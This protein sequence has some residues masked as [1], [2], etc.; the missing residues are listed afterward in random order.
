MIYVKW[1][2]LMLSF[3]MVASVSQAKANSARKKIQIQKSYTLLIDKHLQNGF[4]FTKAYRN[5]KMIYVLS[6]IYQNKKNKQLL[7]TDRKFKEFESALGGLKS[8]GTI[9]RLNCR[10]RVMMVEATQKKQNAS[11]ICDDSRMNP[12]AY[13]IV[14]EVTSE[15]ADLLSLVR[16]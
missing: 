15:M 8:T 16:G 2:Q 1:V 9:N 4:D 13:K 10:S 3:F 7:I 11:Y 6:N 12:Q 5:G 14:D